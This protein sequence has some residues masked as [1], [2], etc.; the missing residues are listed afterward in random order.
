[1]KEL[2]LQNL[3]YIITACVGVCTALGTLIVS[4]CN[5]KKK[6][7]EYEEKTTQLKIEKTALETQKLELEKLMLEGAFII[8]PNCNT[9][10]K[11]KDMIFYTSKTEVKHNE[12]SQEIKQK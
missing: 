9:E 3:P 1:M 6:K 12:I 8:C 5:A 4:I 7:Y 2:I 11:A 10:I